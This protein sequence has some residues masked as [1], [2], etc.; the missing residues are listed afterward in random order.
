[1]NFKNLFILLVFVGAASI[2]PVIAGEPGTASGNFLKMP[3]GA[4]MTAMGGAVIA[5]VDD[6][7]SSYWNPA[8]LSGV[9]APQIALMHNSSFEN[10]FQKYAAYAHP[11]DFGVFAL[12]VYYV[13]A[14]DIQG[15]DAFGE[16]TN[17]VDFYNMAVGVS[18]QREIIRDL[19]GGI[20]LKYITEKLEKHIGTAFAADIGL[21]YTLKDSGLKFG[22]GI[23]NI[24]SPLKFIEEEFP[25]PMLIDV[26]VGYKTKLLGEDVRVEVNGI[27]PSDNKFFVRAGAEVLIRDLLALRVGYDGGYDAGSGL[28]VGVGLGVDVFTLDYGYRA[29]GEIEGMAHRISLAV[30][31]KGVARAREKARQEEIELLLS[32]GKELATQGKH[33][34]AILKFNRV[35]R[36]APDNAEAIDLM[37]QAGERLR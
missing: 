29:F 5:L 2:T 15:Y 27:M 19:S 18:F 21:Q 20:T 3:V 11:V 34:E 28:N 1:M 12:A 7:Y 23:K 24:G 31:F 35:L 10:I 8:G 25:L 13:G 36:I 16:K 6:V 32:E 4:G 26:G 37:K 14:G 33:A 17:N 9:T 30:K 22:A